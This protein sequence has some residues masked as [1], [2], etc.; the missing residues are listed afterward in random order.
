MGRTKRKDHRGFR[1]GRSDSE[2]RL[3]A[4]NPEVWDEETQQGEEFEEDEA[5]EEDADEAFFDTD[6]RPSTF[7][8]VT[9]D[10]D[11]WE[12]DWSTR[13]DDHDLSEVVRR[14]KR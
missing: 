11:V 13:D 8:R 6:D 12:D 1:P 2:R 5:F 3:R 14:A 4:V 10:I 9:T 7:P